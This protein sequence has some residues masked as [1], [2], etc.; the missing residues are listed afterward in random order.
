ME[1]GGKEQLL[2]K[3][4]NKKEL[5][6]ILQTFLLKTTGSYSRRQMMIQLL[7]IFGSFYLAG[8]LKKLKHTFKN[9]VYLHYSGQ[10][11]VQVFCCSGNAQQKA[12]LFPGHI[13]QMKRQAI[14]E[15]LV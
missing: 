3:K 10:Y 15:K 6:K 5:E 7:G 1:P 4:K 14:L 13:R 11:N 9:S 8:H 2:K 12:S